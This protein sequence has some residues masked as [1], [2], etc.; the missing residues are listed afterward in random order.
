MLL[1]WLISS[2][3]FQKIFDLIYLILV[4]VYFFQFLNI[5]LFYSQHFYHNKQSIPTG[6]FDTGCSVG[7]YWLVTIPYGARTPD[8]LYTGCLIWYFPYCVPGSPATIPWR[9]TV[10]VTFIH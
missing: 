8:G 3:G 2:E 9:D 4:L 10:F 7:P 5:K 1:S 6:N